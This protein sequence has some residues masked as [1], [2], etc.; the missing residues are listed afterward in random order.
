MLFAICTMHLEGEPGSFLSGAEVVQ[1]TIPT[2][3]SVGPSRSFLPHILW[4]VIAFNW[5][6][7]YTHRNAPK[8]TQE[9]ITAA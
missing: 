6:N 2:S 8:S 9:I 7:R 1:G 4:H 5:L 3:H